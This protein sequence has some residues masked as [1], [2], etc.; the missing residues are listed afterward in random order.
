MHNMD[1]AS[2]MKVPDEEGTHIQSESS[3]QRIAPTG[4]DLSLKVGMISAFRDMEDKLAEVKE[5]VRSKIDTGIPNK[6]QLVGSYLEQVW[7]SKIKLVSFNVTTQTTPSQF[8]HATVPRVSKRRNTR[9]L[10]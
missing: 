6:S 10:I 7:L 1:E 9:Q 5:P 3:E 8:R 4:Q 2:E